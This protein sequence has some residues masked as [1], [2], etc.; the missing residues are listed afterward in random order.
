M[1][2]GKWEVG[3]YLLVNEISMRLILFYFFGLLCIIKVDAQTASKSYGKIEVTITKEKKRKGPIYC[4]VEIQQ[5]F[6]SGD[7]AWVQ[8]TNKQINNQL[9]SLRKCKKGI[10]LVL[11]QFV[12]YKEGI[13]S[14][15]RALSNVGFGMEEAVIKALKKALHPWQP[16][17]GRRVKS[18]RTSIINVPLSDDEH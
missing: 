15:V 7:S 4:K 16:A 13:F 10:Y 12:I 8:R 1:V 18:Y 9:L 6:T 11:A 3:K 2:S 5:A 17:V 14:D